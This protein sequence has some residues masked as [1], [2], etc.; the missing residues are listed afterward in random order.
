[1]S[2]VIGEKDLPAQLTVE[3]SVEAAYAREIAEV[4]SK[5]HRSL[6]SLIEADKDLAPYIFMNLR[7]RVRE[8][9]MRC[10]Y[11]DG[12]PREGDQPAGPVPMGL[13]G[14]M[15]AQLRDAVRGATS[16]VDSRGNPVRR[17]IVLPHLDLLT[18]SQG[19]LTG[20]AREVIVLLYE[21]PE[22][23]W[24]G[25]KDPSFPLPKVIDNLFPHRISLLG[26]PRNRLPQL[27]T[28]R[29]SRK[30][31]KQFNPWALYKYI[32]GVNAARVRRLLSTLEGEDYPAD[33]KQAYRQLRQATL[34]GT[35][36]IPDVSLERDIGG[37]DKVKKRLRQEILDVL[38]RRDAATSE[39]D[40]SRLEELIPRGMIFWGPPGTGK[41][42][43]AKAMATALGAAITIVSGP[44]LKSKWVGE[45]EE[46]LRHVFY[47]A[48]QSAP[49]IIVFDELDS[50]A[51]ARGTY[52]GSGVEHSMVNQLLTEMDGFHKEELVFVVGT[53]NFVESLDP[54]LLRPGRFEFHLYIP[55]PDA[56][57]RREILKIFDKKMRLQMTSDAIEFA[58]R[59]T[60]DHVEGAASGTRY[61]GD[62]LNA[63][64]RSMARI[65]LREN[66]KDDS[67]PADVERALLEYVE[68]PKLSPSE[69]KVVAVHESG[70]AVAAMFCEH[71]PPIERITIRGDTAGALGY[72]RY[73]D[74]SHRFVVTRAELLDDLCVLL[75]GREAEQLLLDDLSIGSADDLRRA[76]LIARA[77]VEEFGMGGDDIG[78]VRFNEDFR[79]GSTVRHPGLSEQ[80]KSA[81]DKRVRE[82]LA[83]GRARAASILLENRKL[84]ET[85]RDLLLEKKVIDAKGLNELAPGK[86]EGKKPRRPPAETTRPPEPVSNE[87]GK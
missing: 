80:Q 24:L 6:P 74:R 57:D 33:P 27:I 86:N 77:L 81:L 76:T 8:L 52:T 13:M 87:R 58:V 50:F 71:S 26:T 48:R 67:V 30:F 47:K 12:R 18:T 10:I 61:S 46:A 82:L 40:A 60:A 41:T 1:M 64:C 31:G 25:F 78:V 79:D 19:G 42:F 54:A 49:S 85:L 66:R 14:T 11:L 35:L 73:Q 34:T 16:D 43:F 9:G 5:L 45:S 53:T 72:V 51:T 28:Q 63:L 23:V 38:T 70:H 56:D 17:V 62:H 39:E 65:R 7:Q 29:E 32:S 69:E 20:E 83:E 22:I 55:Y 36:E 68:L 44:E 75:G 4:A 2:K 3:Q 84:L 37:Y 21:N 15:I 59:R